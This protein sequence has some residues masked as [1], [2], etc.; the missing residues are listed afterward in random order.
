MSDKP[1]HLGDLYMEAQS[2]LIDVDGR[3]VVGSVRLQLARPAV[4]TVEAEFSHADPQQGV[5]LSAKPRQLEV[6]GQRAKTVVLW[7]YAPFPVTADLIARKGPFVVSVHNVWKGWHG[8]TMAWTANGGMV[9]R[10]FTDQQLVLDCNAGPR[11][12]T[13]TDATITISWHRDT[14]VKLLL[15]G[16]EPT[17]DFEEGR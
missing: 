5:V 3:Q 11:D 15:P 6:A 2:H 10:K 13:F 9:I 12:I 16:V 1:R 14:A 8:N 4:L 17:A 7:D